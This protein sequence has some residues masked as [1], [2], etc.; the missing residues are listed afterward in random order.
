LKVILLAFFCSRQ[1][2][3]GDMLFRSYLDISVIYDS[4]FEAAIRHAILHSEKAL[5][6]FL[7][8]LSSGRFP[9]GVPPHTGEFYMH[10]FSPSPATSLTH[11]S[12]LL[13]FINL[14]VV[15]GVVHLGSQP[16]TVKLSPTSPIKYVV[17]QMLDG[18][19]NSRG[20]VQM[21]I[22]FTIYTA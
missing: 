21:D 2:R 13:Y 20:T 6:L 17:V 5:I 18:L 8:G 22:A 15:C 14:T 7:L 16:V 10:F 9:R 1:M 3:I 11:R 19:T 12:V 4:E